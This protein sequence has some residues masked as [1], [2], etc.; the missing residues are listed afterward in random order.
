MPQGTLSLAGTGAASA[1]LQAC[2]EQARRQPQASRHQVLVEGDHHGVKAGEPSPV[3]YS[4]TVLKSG[5]SEVIFLASRRSS[6]AA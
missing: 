3:S 6:H 2:A 1:S 4:L 5:R